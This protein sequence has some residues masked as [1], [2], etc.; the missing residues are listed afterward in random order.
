MCAASCASSDAARLLDTCRHSTSISC[1]TFAIGAL[2]RTRVK[3]TRHPG[4]SVNTNDNLCLTRTCAPIDD[5]STT[6]EHGVSVCI[7][8]RSRRPSEQRKSVDRMRVFV[9]FCHR[10]HPLTQYSERI[11]DEPI[12]CA[13]DVD[14]SSRGAPNDGIRVHAANRSRNSLSDATT[15]I[16]I[17]NGASSERERACSMNCDSD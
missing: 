6:L 3:S 5:A 15:R 1:V 11:F 4:K 12:D 17:S 16:S 2:P 10:Q 8:T 13:I 7:S 9:V 14:S